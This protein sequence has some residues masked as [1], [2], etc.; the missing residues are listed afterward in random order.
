[1]AAGADRGSRE[2][3]R[4]ALGF[5]AVSLESFSRVRR[6]IPAQS[7][8]PWFSIYRRRVGSLP[9]AGEAKG[10]AFR[11]RPAALFYRCEIEAQNAEQNTGLPTLPMIRQKSRGTEP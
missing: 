2:R 10:S 8:L 5:L 4:Q 7:R 3:E 11:A 1:M 6:A 9:P